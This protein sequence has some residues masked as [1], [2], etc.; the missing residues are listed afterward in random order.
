ML[1]HILEEIVDEDEGEADGSGKQK[2]ET[3]SGDRERVI[4]VVGAGD[5]TGGAIAKKFASE[6]YTACLV[7]RQAS[8]M[9]QLAQD[10][11]DSGGK[12]HAF[13][14]DARNEGIHSPNCFKGN[15]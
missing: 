6:G 9:D 14:V 11:I 15:P 10:I 8:K 7:R 5:A 4:L 13:G 2:A 3:K 12:A 1:R